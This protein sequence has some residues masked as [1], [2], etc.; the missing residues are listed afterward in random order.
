M[1]TED[2]EKRRQEL[3][4]DFAKTRGNGGKPKPKPRP[5]PQKPK[6]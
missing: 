3:H 1:T 6:P 4:T 2:D 5:E